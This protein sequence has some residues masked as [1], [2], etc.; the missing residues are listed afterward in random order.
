MLLYRYKMKI[1]SGVI[2][3][4]WMVGFT[5]VAVLSVAYAVVEFFNENH[6]SY[7]Y[8]FL[9]LVLLNRYSISKLSKFKTMALSVALASSYT[10]VLTTVLPSNLLSMSLCGIYLGLVLV[11]LLVDDVF[12]LDEI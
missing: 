4:H 8:I 2:Y 10:F 12:V 6:F 3:G 11:L 9:M 1:P 7:A 5:T